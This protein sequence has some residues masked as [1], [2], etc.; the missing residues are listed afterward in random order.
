MTAFSDYIY[1]QTSRQLSDDAIVSVADFLE[2]PSP[3]IKKT[4]LLIVSAVWKC[5]AHKAAKGTAGAEFVHTETKRIFLDGLPDIKS[6][7]ADGNGCQLNRGGNLLVIL[8]G[9]KHTAILKSVTGASPLP[10]HVVCTLFC[11]VTLIFAESTG[12]ASAH[13]NYNPEELALQLQSA[14]NITPWPEGR[15]LNDNTAWLVSEN[16]DTS[17]TAESRPFK[18]YDFLPLIKKFVRRILFIE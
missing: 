12:R 17:A 14:S 9:Q 11:L 18:R 10:Y 4:L 5:F 2:E 16:P 13:F 3:A 7:L 8:A 15:G 6:L 1:S